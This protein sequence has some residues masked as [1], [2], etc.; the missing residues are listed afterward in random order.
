M[1]IFNN[2]K[3]TLMMLSLMTF[4]VACPL[5]Q[6]EPLSLAA[7][8][9]STGV[10]VSASGLMPWQFSMHDQLQWRLALSGA[11]FDEGFDEEINDIEYETI[12]LSLAA[13]QI[14]ADWYGFSDGWKRQLFVSAGLMYWDLDM[15]AEADT[16]RPMNLG[17]LP[18]AKDSLASL[19]SDIDGNFALPYISVGWGNRLDGEGGFH[20]FTEL[21]LAAPT[22]RVDAEVSAND[23]NGL[24]TPEDLRREAEEIEDELNKVQ[25]FVTVA[26]TYQF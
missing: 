1:P 22:G 17:G 13:V 18:L 19:T 16:S 7:T 21:G 8:M 15:T 2:P 11:N 10:G 14:G 20:F 23:P 4:S 9:G 25:G 26:L 12:D 3:P 6:S 5:A 24:V